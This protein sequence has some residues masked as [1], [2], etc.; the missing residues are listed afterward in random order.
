MIPLQPDK[1]PVR[2]WRWKDIVPTIEDLDGIPGDYI[3]MACGNGVEVIDFDLKYDVSGT[4]FDDY[5]QLID[6]IDPKLLKKSVVQKTMNNG[7]HFVYRCEEI[8]GNKKLARRPA[9]AQELEE[10]PMDK[11]RVLIETR[12]AGGYIAIA[13]SPGYK[14]L[15]NKLSEI[16]FIS[17][18][19]RKILF[20]AARSFDSIPV[21]DR[22]QQKVEYAKKTEWVGGKSPFDDYNER[23]DVLDVLYS[24]GWQE[25]GRVGQN[26]LLKRPGSSNKH[27]ATFHIGRR[28]FYVFSS[29]SEFDQNKGYS[30][31][32][33]YAKLIHNDDYS[34]AA[35][36]LFNDGF[37]EKSRKAAMYVYGQHEEEVTA[38]NSLAD[39]D[40]DEEEIQRYR[41]GEMPMGISTG[42]EAL[43]PYWLHKPGSL[44]ISNGLSGSGKTV[45]WL[46]IF[47][48]S[49]ILYNWR[50]AIYSGENKTTF[51]KIKLREFYRGKKL[52]RFTDEDNDIAKRFIDNHFV[53][54]DNDKLYNAFEVLTIFNEMHTINPINYGFI[55]PYNS[56]LMPEVG[57]GKT[58]YNMHMEIAGAFRVFT[59]RTGASLVVTMHPFSE[60]ARKVDKQGYSVPPSAAETENGSMWENRADDFLTYHRIKNHPTDWMY[61][62]VHVRKIKT[63]EL[64]G[65]YTEGA[66]PVRFRLEPGGVVY[67]CSCNALS[68]NNMFDP[69]EDEPVPF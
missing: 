34:E 3:G 41:K 5:C 33:V 65:G 59:K 54:L 15:R 4:L 8:E 42:F 61:T 13:P 31:V 67:T 58:A 51:L 66:N 50:F 27:G 1:S 56:L 32:A 10:D 25:T 63:L 40:R 49:A 46:Y 18:A 44:V 19:E 20:D 21:V 39:D 47:L 69:E 14:V 48:R 62:D 23:G 36:A 9:T 52:K 35:K 6:A 55:D 45:L 11:L 37:G 43:D 24:K 7:Y 60:S 30:P 64:G 16:P 57:R 2:G 53:F 38:E 26:I 68:N 29:S 28:V 22:A 17:V 12:G